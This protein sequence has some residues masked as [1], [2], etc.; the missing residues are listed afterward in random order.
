M[1]GSAGHFAFHIFLIGHAFFADTKPAHRRIRLSGSLLTFSACACNALRT[2]IF[3]RYPVCFCMTSLFQQT[4][5]AVCHFGDRRQLAFLKADD[6]TALIQ[7][8]SDSGQRESGI[9]SV[10][11]SP[12]RLS[13][14]SMPPIRCINS[15]AI[16]KP[17]PLP[18]F[19]AE[20]LLPR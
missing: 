20:L 17:R 18:S 9:S 15:F 3:F 10:T 14:F 8:L 12:P 4:E 19:P 1:P 2:D 16:Y 13:H 6:L 7:L 11:E 5:T